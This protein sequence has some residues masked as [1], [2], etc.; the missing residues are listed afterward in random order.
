MCG[1]TVKT[2][3]F[4]WNCVLAVE[5]GEPAG[6]AVNELVNLHRKGR[7]EV[8]LLQ[9][10][11][12]ENLKG[13]RKFPGSYDCFAERLANLGWDDLPRLPTPGV[14]GLTFLGCS[15][16]V[17]ENAYADMSDRLWSII[18]PNRKTFLDDW[19]ATRG[20]PSDEKF[21]GPAFAKFR[22][23]WCDVHS[24]YCHINERRDLFVTTNTNDFQENSDALTPLGLVAV[25]PEE[26]LNRVACV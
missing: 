5:N 8:A 20:E 9:V 17:D 19:I 4:D 10:S 22:N 16:I 1:R 25:S 3:T 11:A 7:I 18:A 23:A 21:S 14:I 12:S 15:Y 2:L 24:A 6:K 26:A 13:T